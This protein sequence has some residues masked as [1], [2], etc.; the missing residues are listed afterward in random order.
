MTTTTAQTLE[1]FANNK[2]KPEACRLEEK[3]EEGGKI[4]PVSR[5]RI[6]GKYHPRKEQ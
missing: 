5:P 4:I 1:C 2:S 6:D 3:E